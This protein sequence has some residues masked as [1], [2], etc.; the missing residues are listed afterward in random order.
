MVPTLILPGI[1]GLYRLSMLET[2]RTPPKFHGL[3]GRLREVA[4]APV[5]VI[6]AQLFVA[7]S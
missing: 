4:G 1:G 7:G 2:R 3:V 5:V 6:D